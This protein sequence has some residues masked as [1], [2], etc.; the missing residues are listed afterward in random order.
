MQKNLKIL[1][2]AMFVSWSSFMA[3]KFLIQKTDTYKN[4]KN[5]C[6]KSHHDFANFDV[7]VIVWNIKNPNIKMEPGFSV[8]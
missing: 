3:K 2:I 6:A 4:V 1:H 5:L 8:N 7:A